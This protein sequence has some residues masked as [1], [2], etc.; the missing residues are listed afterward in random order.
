MMENT[1]K[2]SSKLNAIVS[3]S[4]KAG[5]ETLVPF[6][7]QKG[8]TIYSTGG[9][10]TKIF[11][12]LSDNL[13]S[14][15]VITDPSMRKKQ[16]ELFSIAKSRAGSWFDLPGYYF[17]PTESIWLTDDNTDLG[18]DLLKKFGRK[19]NM[20]T[21]FIQNRKMNRTFNKGNFPSPKNYYVNILNSYDNAISGREN[22]EQENLSSMIESKKVLEKVVEIYD[23]GEHLSI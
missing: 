5:L 21:I 17:C 12:I 15:K 9:T 11:E 4:N 19:A 7:A 10:Y 20:E 2:M 1:K 6:L 16:N 3:V 14:I 8:Y 22:V 23:N 13:K 18:H